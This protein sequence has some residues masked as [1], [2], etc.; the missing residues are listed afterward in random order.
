MH[1]DVSVVR[2]A[3]KTE[4]AGFIASQTTAFGSEVGVQHQ[5]DCGIAVGAAVFPPW[6]VLFGLAYCSILYAAYT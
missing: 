2:T 6:L 4:E 3:F 5:V 1:E